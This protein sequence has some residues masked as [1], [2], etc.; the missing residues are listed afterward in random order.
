MSEQVA[1]A[2]EPPGAP[3]APAEID[4]HALYEAAE[5]QRQALAEQVRQLEEMQRQLANYAEDLRRTFQDSRRRLQQ[6]RVLHEV[7]LQIGA[8][9]DADA[10]LQTTVQALQRL[11]DCQA[12]YV[13]L[14]EPGAYEVRPRITWSAKDGPPPP[15]T[16]RQEELVREA[17]DTGRSYVDIETRDGVTVSSLIVPLRAHG[18]SLGAV[19]LIRPGAPG[20]DDEARHL[21][22]LCTMATA[23]A[24]TNAALY[25]QSQRLALT[26]PLTGLYNRRSLERLL[27]Q[28]LDKA[29][30]LRYPVGV[31]VID[32]DH[33]KQIND[34]YGHDQGDKVLGGVARALRRALRKFDSLGRYG[35]DEFVAI[36]PGCDAEAV[37]TV[38]EKLRAAVAR[39]R[40]PG[41]HGGGVTISVGGSAGEGPD[42]DARSLLQRA[43]RALYQAKA[44]GRNRVALAEEMPPVASPLASG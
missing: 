34:R 30:R 1:P 26:D 18:R 20:F 5:A 14:Q 24:L 39:L 10:V 27:E 8:L 6:M 11:V 32:V 7:N 12:V 29:R 16:P 42:A 28:E 33:F 37:R 31:L 41:L 2:E 9:L 25:E 4:W 13:F 19:C 36:L 40:F 23:S 44:A 35:G 21:V 3:S 15:P 38:G 17:M 22:E 43:D